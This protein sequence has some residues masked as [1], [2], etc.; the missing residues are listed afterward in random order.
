MGSN[1]LEQVKDEMP[2]LTKLADLHHIEVRSVLPSL[3]YICLSTL[4]TGTSPSSHGIADLDTLA[5]AARSLRL[6]RLFDS[7]RGEGQKTLLAV[8]ERD[9]RGVQVSQFADRTILAKEPNDAEIYKSVSEEAR[10][11]RPR[12]MFVHLL[13]ID[14]AGHEYGPYSQEVKAAATRMNSQLRVLLA[15]L[16]GLDYAIMLLADH[17]MH[18]ASGVLGEND[19]LGVHDGSVE[20][21]LAVP[22][23][24]GSSEEIKQVLSV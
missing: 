24:W 22:L 9:V 12:F 8:H 4:L 13:E 1:V 2:V 3:T 15:S 6:D 21:D 18:P 11:H 23:I 14:E 10:L 17:G 7:V 19:Q 20:E 16:T 5:E